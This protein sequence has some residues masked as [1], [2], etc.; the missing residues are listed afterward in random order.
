MQANNDQPTQIDSL[1]K[2][3]PKPEKTNGFD[4][5]SEKIYT[6][7]KIAEVLK[8]AISVLLDDE[9]IS[10]DGELAIALYTRGITTSITTLRGVL[11]NNDN[12]S[13]EIVSLR[14]AINT[15]LEARK[16]K[17]KS[18]YPGIAAMALKNK[19]GWHDGQKIDIGGQKDNPL[20]VT[21]TLS[22]DPTQNEKS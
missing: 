12:N 2:I 8:Q 6:P 17:D 22:H 3:P 10:L 21:I 1:H 7:E 18:M 9:S 19:H 15:I 14:T 4:P 20:D 5:G 11:L 16:C 13:S